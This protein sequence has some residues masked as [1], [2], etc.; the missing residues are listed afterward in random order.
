MITQKDGA[1]WMKEH[2]GRYKLVC[3]KQRNRASVMAC[4]QFLNGHP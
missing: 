3:T 2:R 1:L 4:I